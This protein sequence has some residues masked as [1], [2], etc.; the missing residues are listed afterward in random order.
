MFTQEFN[1]GI[2][3]LLPKTDSGVPELGHFRPITLLNAD[4]NLIAGLVA[5]TRIKTNLEQL[6][7]ETQTGFVPR[8]IL[9][10]LTLFAM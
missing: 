5:E 10:N 1:E 2:V 6:V 4:Y 3:A 7:H 8:L 9:Y